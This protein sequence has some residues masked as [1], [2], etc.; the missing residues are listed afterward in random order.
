[1]EKKVGT[2]NEYINGYEKSDTVRLH[3]PGHKGKAIPG[4]GDSLASMYKRDITEIEGADSLYEA[5]GI[6]RESERRTAALY[7]S[8]ETFYSAGGS[9][10]CIKAMCMMALMNQ[11]AWDT[12]KVNN[13]GNMGN[14]GSTGN[15]G[16]TGNPIILAG[17]NAHK[18]FLYASGFLRFDIRW[19]MSEGKPESGSEN[20]PGSATGN[21]TG[22]AK[23]SAT[24]NVT[25]NVTGSATGN[26]MANVTGSVTGS[27]TGNVM[28]NVTGSVTG[29]ATG[30]VMGSARGSLCECRITPEGLG[31]RLEELKAEGVLGRVAAVYITSSDYLGNMQ[32]IAGLAETTHKYGKLL[33]VDNAH[34]AYLAALRENI[35]PISLG[36]DMTADSAHKTLPVLTGGSYLHISTNSPKGLEEYARHALEMSGS[37]SPSYLIM[38]SMDRAATYLEEQQEK[39]AAVGEN[40]FDICEGRVRKLGKKLSSLGFRVKSSE[41]SEPFKLTIDLTSN[42]GK[43]GSGNEQKAGSGGE[44]KAGSGGEQKAGSGGELSSLLRDKGVEC[45]F[46][47]R[48]YLV[49]MFS[50]MN[51]EEDFERTEQAFTEIAAEAGQAYTEA[52]ANTGRGFTEADANTGRGF[53]EA[54]ANTGRGFTNVAVEAGQGGMVSPQVVYQF[55]EIM[56]A[57]GEWI[58]TEKAE[59]FIALDIPVSCPPA[60]LPVVPGERITSDMVA[61]LKYYNIPRVKVLK[62]AE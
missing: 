40:D 31:K 1:M 44:Q 39:R 21:V 42:M 19:L 62:E 12:D 29:S 17:R 25:A 5:D 46:A 43:A 14:P 61:V 57:P 2:I 20:A 56:T 55:H 11:N 35:H 15:P 10:Q 54:D 22:S 23:G 28:A 47:D 4:S 52:D 36:A 51:T 38:D 8:R 26:V 53:T 13:P 27:V 58:D 37:T 24:G 33:L 34:G 50:T 49:M 3:M 41:L 16:G 6:I 48:D 30:N 59:G 9:S 32:D 60:V 45:E 7:G 18:A